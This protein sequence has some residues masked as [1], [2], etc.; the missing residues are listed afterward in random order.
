MNTHMLG[1]PWN[2]IRSVNL[3]H[4]IKHTLQ[5]FALA[6][7]LSLSPA[8]L[9]E[10]YELPL[11]TGSTTS[12]QQGM[13]RILNHSDDSGSVSIVAI[14]DAGTRS[15]AATLALGALAGVNLGASDL[16]SGNASKGVTGSIGGL[17]G[18]VR[19]EFDTDLA[20]QVLAY[21]RTS[22]GTLSVLH[23]EVSAATSG[24][25]GSHSYLVPT[26][27]AAQEM[28]QM[29]QLRLVNPTGMAATVSIE[30]R[31]DSGAVATGGRVGLTL[32]AGGATT[33]TAQQLEAGGTG[34]TGQ[35]GAGSG[36]WRLR[37]SSDQPIEVISLV[38]SSTGHVANLST[39]GR[40]VMEARP[41]T[42]L[43]FE[44]GS[45]P[46]NQ[47]YTVDTAIST[48]A[49]PEAT[50]GN[51]TLTYSLIPQVSGLAFDA[52]TRQLSGT[53]TTADAHSMTYTATDEDG[54]TATLGFTITVQALGG[55]MTVGE[56]D[57]YVSLQVS[58]GESCTYPGTDSAF[59]VDA[60]GRGRFLVINSTRAI[61]VNSVNYQGTF[62]DFRASH[63]GDGVWRIDR[64]DGSTEAPATP[65]SGGGGEEPGD[66]M[67]SFAAD[68]GPG[69][70][71]FTVGAAIDALSLPAA[72]GGGRHTRLH[73]RTRGSGPHL[74][75]RH[76]PSHG[77]THH[78]RHT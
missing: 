66:A 74:R 38:E 48:L 23:G 78:R 20:I 36:R 51:G 2:D 34:L 7:L 28:S 63:E 25:D 75:R 18:N 50:G 21:L 72:T 70:R 60:D 44:D 6:S 8:A 52:T 37:L 5:R 56:G 29:S 16:E 3:T 54:D 9:A 12:G 40:G 77:D 62:Y 41:D 24:E 57:C 47:I 19:L 49:L 55:G 33:I 27:N 61:N 45:A 42:P 58:P 13:V 76:A 32:P 22:D 35:F 10:K 4:A 68:A 14:D 30:G 73:A 26:F 67:P 1:G 17:Q 53:P 65:P 31:D 43:S 15:S 69:D 46:D 11:F 59:T 39:P 64:I 71:T